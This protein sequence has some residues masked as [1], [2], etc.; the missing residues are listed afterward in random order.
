VKR[1][2]RRLAFSTVVL[3]ALIPASSRGQ[4]PS[5]PDSVAAPAARDT[6][7]VRFDHGRTEHV[8]LVTPLPMGRVSLEWGDGKE[9]LVGDQHVRS[10]TDAHGND[11]TQSVLQGHN[12]VGAWRATPREGPG[13]SEARHSP[14]C[15]K[16]HPEPRCTTCLLTE[17]AIV[18]SGESSSE[19]PYDNSGYYLILRLGAE[20]NLGRR[21]A[22]GADLY[23]AF[24]PDVARYGIQLRYRRWL[25][26][27]VALDL[28]PGV[29]L[30]SDSMDHPDTE[31]DPGFVGEIGLTFGGW[32]GVVA[33]LQ[34]VSWHGD[35]YDRNGPGASRD[36]TDTRGYFG[37]NLSGVPGLVAMALGPLLYSGVQHSS[38]NGGLL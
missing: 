21:Q 20:R 18:V 16:Q 28:A 27:T 34:S 14:L 5:P 26:P 23:T 12:T 35:V 4:A 8:A 6:I 25:S 38:L 22:V 33:G 13:A 36:G 2:A 37:V 11:L 9:E 31:N 7:T 3:C 10:I 15:L 1:A 19:P 32:F 30:G 17:F 24:N 29:L